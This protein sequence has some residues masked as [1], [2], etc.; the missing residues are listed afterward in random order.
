MCAT[1][2]AYLAEG[3]KFLKQHDK[4]EQVVCWLA[5]VDSSLL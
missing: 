3:L 4:N 1:V 5:K 2:L